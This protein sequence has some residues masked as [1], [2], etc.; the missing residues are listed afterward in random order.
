MLDFAEWRCSGMAFLD[1]PYVV[2]NPFLNPGSQKG[3]FSLRISNK[4]R[5]ETG[6]LLTMWRT[7]RSS[8]VKFESLDLSVI[9]L[10]VIPT[11]ISGD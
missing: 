6:G 11:P 3:W 1:N 5:V 7:Q 10:V 2:D 8:I 9:S 4:S